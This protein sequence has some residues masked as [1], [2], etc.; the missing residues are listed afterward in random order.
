MKLISMRTQ[1]FMKCEFAEVKF[2]TD[3]VQICGKNGSGKSSF[4]KSIWAL[5]GGKDGIPREPV[6]EGKERST[7]HAELDGDFVLTKTIETD[8]TTSLELRNKSGGKYRAPQDILKG[9]NLRF[10]FW[11][12]EWIRTKA[13]EQAATLRKVV[14]LD[15]SKEDSQMAI[16]TQERLVIGREL[17]ILQGQLAGCKEHSDAPEIEISSSEIV[18]RLKEAQAAVAEKSR[19]ESA[20]RTEQNQ[21]DLKS[22]EVDRLKERIAQLESEIADHEKRNLDFWARWQEVE[23]PDVEAIEQELSA[24]ESNNAKARENKQ[25]ATIRAQV[26]TKFTEYNLYTTRLKELADH[27]AKVLAEAKFPV[28]GLGFDESGV[29]YQGKPF[30]QASKA[31]Q[32]EVAVGIGFALNPQLKL[33]YIEDGSLLDTDTLERVE[34]LV[35]DHG[36]QLLLETVGDSSEAVVMFADGVAHLRNPNTGEWS[37]QES[38]DEERT[39]MPEVR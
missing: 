9:F 13:T 26:D 34:S 1:N 28:P 8:G 38:S 12:E 33:V 5:F 20:A 37:P 16:L 21:G 32:W 27:K 25:H 18:G 35:R 31:Q 17:K 15:F 14:G 10:G 3:V 29:T 6:T 11:P 2:D 22:K 36:G 19:L 30:E 23:V 4:A 24:L 39:S 7:L